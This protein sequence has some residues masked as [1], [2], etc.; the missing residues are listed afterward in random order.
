MK[1]KED[2]IFVLSFI[3]ICFVVYLFFYLRNKWVDKENKNR[4]LEAFRNAFITNNFIL[5][6]K[7]EWDYSSEIRALGLK[8]FGKYKRVALD[9]IDI[10]IISD[11]FGF[12]VQPY[13]KIIMNHFFGGTLTNKTEGYEGISC[14]HVVFRFY[15]YEYICEIG[16][17]E[18]YNVNVEKHYGSP[19][20][21]NNEM[22][23][24]YGIGEQEFYSIVKDKEDVK[25]MW[26]EA[27]NY[28]F[29]K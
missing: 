3:I 12:N 11:I 15:K 8:E 25:R 17:K 19:S 24:N 18:V 23:Y 16:I 20:W 4:I 1:S 2:P 7:M 10:D 21:Y 27:K 14:H 22:H 28:M 5:L 29:R 9:N 6:S 13:D 26:D